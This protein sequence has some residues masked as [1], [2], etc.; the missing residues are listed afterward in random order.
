M[1]KLLDKFLFAVVGR[2]GSLLILL[3]GKTLTIKWV[4]E[5][6]RTQISGAVVY[7]FWHSRLLILAFSH[8]RRDALTMVSESK[9]GEL[10]A[11]PLQRLGFVPVRGS[12][13]RSGLK[14]LFRMVKGISEGREGSLT[15]DGPR[16][17]CQ[18]AQIG[19]ILIAQRAAVPIMPIVASAEKCWR[20]KSWDRFMIPKPFSRIV[21]IHG[22]PIYVPRKSSED[23]LEAKRLEL[24]N[25]LNAITEKAD[26]FFDK[27]C[28]AGISVD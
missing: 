26:H 15:P 1:K 14:A 7:A 4:D 25:V 2:L 12:S 24:E 20:L 11:R 8:R 22:E 9:D 13:S 5:H 17:P 6:Y 27:S 3:L 21:I 19:T 28:I 23:E 18:R 16:G 10:I